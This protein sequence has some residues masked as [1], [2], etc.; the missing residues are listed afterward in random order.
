MATPTPQPTNT[1]K[2]K[3]TP[4]VPAAHFNEPDAAFYAALSPSFFR[5]ARRFGRGPAYYKF[6]RRIVYSVADLDAWLAAHR[7]SHAA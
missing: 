7:V 3:R 1:D 4:A 6:G 5:K 2:P